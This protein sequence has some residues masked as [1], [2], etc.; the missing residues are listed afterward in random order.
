MLVDHYLKYH[1]VFYLVKYHDEVTVPMLSLSKISL[2][3]LLSEIPWWNH[4]TNVVT[5]T[6]SDILDSDKV[7]TVISSWYFTK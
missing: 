4:S 3:V 1:Y 5:R 7:G 2:C 6:P